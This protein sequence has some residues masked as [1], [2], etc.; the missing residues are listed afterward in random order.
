MAGQ[1]SEVKLTLVCQVS[2]A[3]ANHKVDTSNKLLRSINFSGDGKVVYL[4]NIAAAIISQLENPE[5]PEFIK[6]PNYNEQKWQMKTN[7]GS[8][9]IQL[10]QAKELISRAISL[11]APAYNACMCRVH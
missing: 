11:G 8:S 1:F 7:S 4:G 6:M 9:F 10:K 5:T 3:K 2:K